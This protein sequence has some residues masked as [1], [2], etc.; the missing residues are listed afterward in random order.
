MV[1]GLVMNSFMSGHNL[2]EGAG[3]QTAVG[4][5]DVASAIPSGRYRSLGVD[6][7]RLM[8][9]YGDLFLTAF[10]LPLSEV[11]QPQN[12]FQDNY[13]LKHGHRLEGTSS[14]YRVKTKPI[15]GPCQ[16]PRQLEIVVKHCRVGQ[17]TILEASIPTKLRGLIQQED[18]D[19]V[20]WNGPFEEFG[21]V[22]ELRNGEFGPHVMPMVTQE[23]LAIF[24]P[25]QFI[26]PDSYGRSADSFRMSNN[27]MTADSSSNSTDEADLLALD[28]TK[29]YYMIY[30]WVSGV[31]ARELGRQ[32]HLTEEDLEYLTINTFHKLRHKG[33]IVL[34]LKPAHMILFQ[35]E[36]CQILKNREE[37]AYGL[38]DYELLIRTQEYDKYHRLNRRRQY[39]F[40]ISR[41]H[42][43]AMARNMPDGLQSVNILGV[44]YIFGPT[45]QGGKLWVLGYNPGLF[46]YFQPSRWRNAPRIRL[47][48][49]TDKF[50]TITPGNIH[51]VYRKSRV[52]I[53][54]QRDP[55]EAFPS[56]VFEHGYNSP[57]E[58]VSFAETLRQ[59][60]VKTVY[61]RAIYRTGQRSELTAFLLDTSR[62][63]AMSDVQTPENPPEPVLSRVHEYYTVWG[64]WRGIDP[65]RDYLPGAHYGLTTIEQV[66]NDRIISETE[67]QA[68]MESTIARL[69]NIHMQDLF[70]G[71]YDFL[72]SFN[73]DRQTLKRD[74]R[75]HYEI[76]LCIDAYCA[77]HYRLLEADQYREIIETTHTDLRRAGFEMLNLA[78]DHI[79]LSAN[80]DGVIL[81]EEDGTFMRTLCNFELMKEIAY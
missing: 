12:W 7:R 77:Y 76:T 6:Y 45:P 57:F 17:E 5:G 67:S 58:E 31:D 22:M 18:L 4:T 71:K 64:C 10:G 75:G 26:D 28:I 24:V 34:D 74:A 78:G 11:L 29:Q 9:P 62:Y 59:V 70:I 61:P 66:L 81:K 65:E 37:F 69:R 51:L 50:H 55:L 38:V 1:R 36:D 27:V 33:F 2:F 42:D 14:V 43:P 54:P 15:E 44:P 53:L 16:G 68:I 3:P 52:G 35:G 60:G 32:Q 20:R 47:S 72:L 56:K 80:P 8:T 21:K 73:T 41:R 30:S 79:L 39:W 23:P 25:A 49:T 40:D 19:N 63:D 48:G 13:Y 46:E